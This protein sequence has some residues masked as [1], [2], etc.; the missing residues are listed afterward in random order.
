M[1]NPTEVSEYSIVLNYRVLF[2]ILRFG[3]IECVIK[4]N[5]IEEKFKKN[6]KKCIYTI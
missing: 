6:N 5:K 2:I 3:R 1:I 4:C